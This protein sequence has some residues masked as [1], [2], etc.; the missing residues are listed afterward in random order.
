MKLELTNK[1]VSYL[2]CALRLSITEYKKRAKLSKDLDKK[3]IVKIAGEGINEF[4]SLL[5]ILKTTYV[6]L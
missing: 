3:H 6:S 5:N 1:E 4:T 2:Q